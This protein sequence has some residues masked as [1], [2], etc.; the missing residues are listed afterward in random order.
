MKYRMYVLVTRHLSPIQKGIQGAHAIVEYS[1]YHGDTK[2]YKAW[3]E[4]DKTIVMLDMH[5]VDDLVGKAC[6]TLY[7]A[8]FPY[9]AFTEM[10]LGNITTAVAFLADERIFDYDTYGRSYDDYAKGVGHTADYHTWLKIIG[11]YGAEKVKE[12][13]SELRT[14]I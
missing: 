8:E 2:E 5:S 7:E 9:A 11:G 1:R 10:D 14:A 13:V 3:S 4:N 12:L 6:A